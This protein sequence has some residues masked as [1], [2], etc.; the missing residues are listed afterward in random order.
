[1]KLLV[2]Q[3]VS[4]AARKAAARSAALLGSAA[5]GTST[6][7]NRLAGGMRSGTDDL[8]RTNNRSGLSVR[9]VVMAGL[10]GLALGHLIDDADREDSPTGRTTNG[11]VDAG[12]EVDSALDA[13]V[14]DYADMSPFLREQL[15]ILEADGWTIGYGDIDSLGVTYSE[16]KKI[17][18]DKDKKDEPLWATAI[19]AHEVGHAYAGRFDAITDP[20]TPGEEY[21]PWLE[22]NMRMRY[23]AEAESGLTTARAR[24]EILENGGPDIGNISQATIDIWADENSGRLS[25]DEARD[26]LADELGRT[27]YQHYRDDLEQTW[28]DNFA[29]THG[30]SELEID[31]P[32]LPDSPNIPDNGVIVEPPAQDNNGYDPLPVEEGDQ[33]DP[34]K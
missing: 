8:A 16:A 20:P 5:K 18:I 23:L 33:H 17:I 12:P 3:A 11:P 15:K 4:G 22:R 9:H 28:D 32:V 7:Y 25:H 21:G 24:M 13:T 29:D 27:P 1:M 19:L 6:T 34:P 14:L 10:G 30:P 2:S 26:R 31:I